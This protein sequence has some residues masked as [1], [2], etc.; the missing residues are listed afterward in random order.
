MAIPLGPIVHPSPHK[1]G[2]CRFV[3]LRCI[4]RSLIKHLGNWLMYGLGGELIVDIW[5]RWRIETKEE[6]RRAE[7]EQLAQASA[8]E[9]A[10]EVLPV[11]QEHGGALRDSDK[12][13]VA[14]YLKQ[15]PAM[16]RR[17]LRRPSD[18]TGTTIPP[19][20]SL[21]KPE[22]LLPMLPKRMPRFQ[23]GDRP[24]PGV[25]WELEELLGV[26]GFGEVW[27]A[28]NPHFAGL[29]PVALKFCLNPAVK[30]RLL[31]HEAAILTRVMRQGKHEGIVALHQT[32]L[33]TDPP[34]LEYEYINGSDLGVWIKE[35][36]RPGRRN[37]TK[38]VTR[39]ILRLAEIVAIAHHVDPPIVH[40]DLKPA[41]ILVETGPGGE[42]SLKITDFGIGGL[43]AHQTVERSEEPTKRDAQ[44]TTAVHG[45]YTVLYSSPQQMRGDPPDPRDDVY[46]LGIMWYQLLIGDLTKAVPSEWR[47]ELQG[48]GLD[49]CQIDLLGSC[50]SSRAEKRPANAGVLAE[51]LVK[52]TTVKPPLQPSRSA[53]PTNRR[54]FT[55]PPLPAS[56]LPPPPPGSWLRPGGPDPGANE[57]TTP[58]VRASRG[59]RGPW[60]ALSVAGCSVLL[61]VVWFVSWL[62]GVMVDPNDERRARIGTEDAGA[63]LHVQGET[64]KTEN[65]PPSSCPKG[66][67]VDVDGPGLISEHDIAEKR[68]KEAAG[69]LR[70]A[71]RDYPLPFVE[72]TPS[73]DLTLSDKAGMRVV[74]KYSINKDAYQKYIGELE[75]V[76]H[77]VAERSGDVVLRMGA[78]PGIGYWEPGFPKKDA[79][80]LKAI[81]MQEKETNCR[82]LIVVKSFQFFGESKV[83]IDRHHDLDATWY[84]LK[85]E[86]STVFPSVVGVT[87]ELALRCQLVTETGEIVATRTVHPYQ[88]RRDATPILL[89][90]GGPAAY[91]WSNNS[92]DPWY[93]WQHLEEHG[94]KEMQRV[95]ILLP[96]LYRRNESGQSERRNNIDLTIQFDVSPDEIKKVKKLVVTP[97]VATAGG[98]DK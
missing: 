27:K 68:A 76:L 17:T 37:R 95:M 64:R 60:L 42:C 92:L 91:F 1:P 98:R 67:S 20:L 34:C 46:S 87:K 96:F 36:H 31:K 65:A 79:E 28:K 84:E 94:E 11:L 78:G 18:L 3:L 58:L 23:P 7:V 15:V 40:R 48:C 24:L 29:R 41:N 44:L 43:A 85:G 73:P 83:V 25:D 49:E 50:I 70:D 26:G 33:S 5:E 88:W 8:K 80:V 4:A 90:P 35:W 74:V 54:P 51:V 53:D 81:L 56:V 10:E 55:P 30:E 32:F 47:E 69:R 39:I 2:R 45:A 59:K 86:P 57:A 72:F 19:G 16:I 22:D 38:Q 63:A 89:Y 97:E 75:K 9:V 13:Q 6:Q 14:N 82:F 77:T 62:M 93:S 21:A 12:R 61:L 66:T 71:L 52:L